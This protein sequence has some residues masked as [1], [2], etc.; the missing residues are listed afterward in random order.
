MEMNDQTLPRPTAEIYAR[1]KELEKAGDMDAFIDFH[2]Q[3]DWTTEVFEEYG[4]Y[5]LRSCI[6]EILVPPNYD[7]FKLLTCEDVRPGNK[8]VAS[9]NFKFGIIRAGASGEWLVKPEY[10]DIGFP[11]KFTSVRIGDKW[12]VLN[13]EDGKLHLPVE[14]DEIYNGDSFMFINGIGYLVKDK[15]FTVI[16]DFGEYSEAV[17]DSAE[18]DEFGRIEVTFKGIKGFIDKDGKF[19]TDEDEAYFAEEV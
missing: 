4:F 9:E 1:Y 12:G 2:N 10:D 7:D 14:Y 19:T 3:Y 18:P 6:G 17:F 15:K 16:N 11:N 13:T 8:I 5:G